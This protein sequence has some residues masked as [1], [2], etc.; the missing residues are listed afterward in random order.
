MP[1]VGPTLG[2]PGA[3]ALRLGGTWVTP[4][5][6]LVAPGWH[7]PTFLVLGWP[8]LAPRLRLGGT[9]V[10]PGH[11][12]G[13]HQ[14]NPRA[15]PRHPQGTPTT[16]NTH[17][18]RILCVTNHYVTIPCAKGPYVRDPCV[19]DPPVRNPYVRNRYVTKPPVTDPCVRDPG[20]PNLSVGP[21]VSWGLG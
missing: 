21:K 19:R 2:Y 17:Q 10:A 5:W 6:H 3:Q 16:H 12:Q 4:A 15:P 1:W 7:L 11:L 18:E 14:D 9:W 8:S 13:T 20:V